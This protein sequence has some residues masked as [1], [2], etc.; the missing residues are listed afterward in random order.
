MIDAGTGMNKSAKTY[1]AHAVTT[2]MIFPAK[3]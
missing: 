2:G 1:G 3:G